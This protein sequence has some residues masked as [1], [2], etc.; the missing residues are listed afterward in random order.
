MTAGE[1]LVR[2]NLVAAR[3]LNVLDGQQ[4]DHY[5]NIV[6]AEV[7]DRGLEILIG[8][9]RGPFSPATAAVFTQ[10]NVQAQ[11]AFDA[12][13]PPVRQRRTQIGVFLQTIET[14]MTGPPDQQT[15]DDIQHNLQQ[16]R[17]V[18]F[19]GASIDYAAVRADNA[20]LRQ[21]ARQLLA[22][23][24]GESAAD[25]VVRYLDDA[26]EAAR[27]QRAPLN[28][29]ERNVRDY[30]FI[31]NLLRGEGWG[32]VLTESGLL[33]GEGGKHGEALDE[34]LMAASL[35]YK[36]DAAVKLGIAKAREG[37]GEL[38]LAISAYNA[39]LADAP[40]DADANTALARLYRQKSAQ[41]RRSVEPQI[42]PH[43]VL[44][45]AR[46]NLTPDS[47][48]AANISNGRKASQLYN[49]AVAYLTIP[50]QYPDDAIRLLQSSLALEPRKE[51]YSWLAEA[52]I[53][54]LGL[55][56]PS[57]VLLFATRALMGSMQWARHLVR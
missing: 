57:S 13:M 34:L 49:L 42:L 18:A 15:F 8:E 43:N 50:P 22:A 19:V 41:A 10:A 3:V 32:H 27:R 12:A 48:D 21:E 4:Q 25:L 2:S 14:I 44:A 37:L 24:Q 26:L 28:G 52:H 51:T 56:A 46:Q 54:Q 36:E 29:S 16:L 40:V 35:G 23:Q 45:D 5:R 33:L 38:D 55:E 17:G 11:A 20:R 7:A 39:V 53:R 9:V 30:F 1:G 31:H 6:T 47:I